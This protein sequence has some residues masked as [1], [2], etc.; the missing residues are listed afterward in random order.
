MSVDFG[1]QK[2]SW[3]EFEENG[4]LGGGVHILTTDIKNRPA[5]FSRRK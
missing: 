2:E 1:V 3:Y 4:A 5:G